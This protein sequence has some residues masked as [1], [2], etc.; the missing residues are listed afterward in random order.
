MAALEYFPNCRTCD[1]GFSGGLKFFDSVREVLTWALENIQEYELKEVH[2]TA[3]GRIRFELGYEYGRHC[4]TGM[5]FKAKGL[6]MR[7][8]DN[9][10]GTRIWSKP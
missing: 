7:T 10:S 8:V 1:G 9:G 5:K 2:G 3:T 6:S 4:C